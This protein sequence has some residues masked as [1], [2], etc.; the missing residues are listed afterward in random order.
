[1]NDGKTFANIAKSYFKDALKST[2]QSVIDVKHIMPSKPKMSNS[3]K[4]LKITES[5]ISVNI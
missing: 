1:M 5:A 2:F 3:D 4:P